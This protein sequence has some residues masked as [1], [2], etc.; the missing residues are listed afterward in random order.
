[1][2]FT[3]YPKVIRP[4]SGFLPREAQEWMR[5]ALTEGPPGS[6]SRMRAID[7]VY[8]MIEEKYPEYLIY[9]KERR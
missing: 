3:K 1:M 7:R 4:G 6:L 9:G 8:R 5:Q 2:I